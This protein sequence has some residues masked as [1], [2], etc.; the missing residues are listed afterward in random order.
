MKN[1]KFIL[2]I[3]LTVTIVAVSLTSRAEEQKPKPNL[4]N[5]SFPITSRQ[6][7]RKYRKLD[8]LNA[9]SAPCAAVFGKGFAVGIV[10]GNNQMFREMPGRNG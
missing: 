9:V 2:A 4:R 3:I 5:P 8:K 6:V 10:R 1:L 7:C